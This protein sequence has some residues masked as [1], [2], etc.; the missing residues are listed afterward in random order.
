MPDNPNTKKLSEQ[1]PLDAEDWE[2]AFAAYE[3]QH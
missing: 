2:L 3:G 1:P